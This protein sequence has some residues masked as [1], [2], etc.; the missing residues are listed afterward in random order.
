VLGELSP[1]NATIAAATGMLAPIPVRATAYVESPLWTADLA[2]SQSASPVY[3]M[4][5]ARF[6]V[7]PEATVIATDRAPVRIEAPRK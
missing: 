2:T 3:V 1:E 5:I 6:A 4:Q 7:V